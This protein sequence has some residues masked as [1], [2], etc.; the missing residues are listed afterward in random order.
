METEK[1]KPC[2]SA[3]VKVKA[4]NYQNGN[5]METKGEITKTA[6]ECAEISGEDSLTF[7]GSDCEKPQMEVN[8]NSSAIGTGEQTTDV[9]LEIKGSVLIDKKEVD[10]IAASSKLKTVFG[11]KGQIGKVEDWFKLKLENSCDAKC[12][13]TESYYTTKT[14]EISK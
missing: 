11:G 4:I 3:V 12:A 7:R 8:Y 5:V 2:F 6:A 1:V 9:D 10:V 13:S 14:T